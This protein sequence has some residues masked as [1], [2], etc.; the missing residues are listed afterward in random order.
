MTEIDTRAIVDYE[1]SRL[2]R[3]GYLVFAGVSLLG[4]AFFLY[5]LV[6]IA[7]HGGAGLGWWVVLLFLLFTAAFAGLAVVAGV[8]AFGPSLRISL[9]REGFKYQGLFQVLRV[10]W[11][12]VESYRLSHGALFD[13]LRVALGPEARGGARKLMLDVSNLSPPVADVLA[14]FADAIGRKELKK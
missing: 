4:L 2:G 6:S 8:R 7:M 5:T 9:T 1:L 13:H 11:T 3:T 14:T 10:R 12:E